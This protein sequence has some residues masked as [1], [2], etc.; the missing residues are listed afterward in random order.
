MTPASTIARLDASLARSGSPVS[1]YRG[2][3]Y[4]ECQA[5][6]KGLSAQEL[7]P[8]STSGQGTFRAILSPTAF[9]A[10]GA[11]VTLPL[12]I[13]DAVLFNGMQRKIT[14][15]WPVM[16]GGQVVRIEADFMG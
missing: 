8:G 9:T 12:K 16:M 13:N 1:V 5:K 6:V 14:Y 10:D 7:R 15:V 2:A 4:V 11:A 3:A